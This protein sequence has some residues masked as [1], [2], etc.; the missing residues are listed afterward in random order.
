LAAGARVFSEGA[1]AAWYGCGREGICALAVIP[2][3]GTAPGI[4]GAIL[5]IGITAPGGG[6]I[7]E[8]A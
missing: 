7:V 6:V 5:G 3:G 8:G 2:D 4:A 1:G